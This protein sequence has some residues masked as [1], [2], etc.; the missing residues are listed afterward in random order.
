MR[1]QKREKYSWTQREET[2]S[3]ILTQDP[4]GTRRGINT[5]EHKERKQ[6]AIMWHRIYEKPEEGE[7]FMNTKRGNSQR[8]SDKCLLSCIQRWWE[9]SM[10]FCVIIFWTLYYIRTSKIIWTFWIQIYSDY[11]LNSIYIYYSCFW[12]FLFCYVIMYAIYV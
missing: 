9:I 1:N 6:S 10:N 4:G 12:L 3:D 11:H 2:V 5:H 8:Y 7:I